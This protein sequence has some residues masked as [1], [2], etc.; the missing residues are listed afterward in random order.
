MREQH[1]RA[2]SPLEGALW[3]LRYQEKQWL[4]EKA[5]PRRDAEAQRKLAARLQQKLEVFS[6]TSPDVK[7]ENIER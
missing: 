2:R 4:A 3:E 5:T 6:C 7:H 1:T